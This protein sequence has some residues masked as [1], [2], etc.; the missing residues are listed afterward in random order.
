MSSIKSYMDHKELKFQVTVGRK[1]FKGFNTALDALREG[2]ARAA[3]EDARAADLCR[4]K[5]FESRVGIIF[6]AET[7]QKYCTQGA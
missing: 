7:K 2:I 3:E 4:D 6:G 5:S 1:T